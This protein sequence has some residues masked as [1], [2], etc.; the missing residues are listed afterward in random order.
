M[1]QRQPEDRRKSL[2]EQLRQA[3]D[4]SRDASLPLGVQ[5]LLEGQAKYLRRRLQSLQPQQPKPPQPESRK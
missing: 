5:H 3:E 1:S 4:Q 2:E